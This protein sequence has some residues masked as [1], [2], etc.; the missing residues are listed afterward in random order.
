MTA[1]STSPTFTKCGQPCCMVYNGSL[2]L[3]IL[4]MECW[5]LSAT[6][7]DTMWRQSEQWSRCYVPLAT[8]DTAM[9]L[10]R[11]APVPWPRS[12]ILSGSPPK[13]G[14]F[15]LSQCSPATRSMSPKLPWALPLAPVLRNPAAKEQRLWSVKCEVWSGQPEAALPPD[16]SGAAL[17]WWMDV[18]PSESHQSLTLQRYGAADEASRLSRNAS[19]PWELTPVRCEVFTAVTMKNAVFWDI[20]T[21]F[22]LH[23]RYITSPLE[24]PAY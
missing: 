4:R 10:L 14:M 8:G 13:A 21:Q 17:A 1:F 15:S 20:R 7:Q 5:N 12:V 23:S 19:F 18:L 6:P 22:V 3:D 24:S 16:C 9:M 2:L 11:A